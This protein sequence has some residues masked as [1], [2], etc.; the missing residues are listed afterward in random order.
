MH[1]SECLISVHPRLA[2]LDL[3]SPDYG[4]Y[5]NFATTVSELHSCRSVVMIRSIELMMADLTR[6][7]A[8]L[9]LTSNRSPNSNF[10]NLPVC[11]LVLQHAKIYALNAE[12]TL[13]R[14]IS[15]IS[16]DPGPPACLSLHLLR[17][18][19]QVDFCKDVQNP[20]RCDKI[21]SDIHQNKKFPYSLEQLKEEIKSTL[22]F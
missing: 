16:E 14:D 2:A 4:L 3:I 7:P 19:Y 12:S 5:S 10:V 18:I 15:E 8:W 11:L 9:A 1:Y 20:Q 6:L 13:A 22:L 21:Y 17:V